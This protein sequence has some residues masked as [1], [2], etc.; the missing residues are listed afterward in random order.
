MK[1]C[2]SQKRNEANQRA[3]WA[4]TNEKEFS[5]NFSDKF[6]TKFLIHSNTTT[7]RQCHSSVALIR[8]S[9]TNQHDKQTKNLSIKVFQQNRRT[10]YNSKPNSRCNFYSQ[11]R[12]NASFKWFT[13]T[14][15]FTGYLTVCFSIGIKESVKFQSTKSSLHEHQT[16]VLLML[17]II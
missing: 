10:V 7:I 14:G 9:Q 6:R 15:Q 8:V 17:C 11:T 1:I 16:T 13:T 4:K 12:W 3:D 5:S 2:H